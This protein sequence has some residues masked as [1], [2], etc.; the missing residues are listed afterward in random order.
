MAI[1]KSI[2]STRIINGNAIKTSEIAIVSENDYRTNGEY[3]IIIKGVHSC[4]LTL[5]SQ[6]TDHVVVKSLTKVN[7]IPDMGRI[8][9]EWDEIV[10]DEFACVEFIFAGGHWWIL[11]SDGLKQS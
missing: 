8:D 7:V 9:E 6:T 10:L 3:V 2:P 4:E 1:V 5:D 11:S